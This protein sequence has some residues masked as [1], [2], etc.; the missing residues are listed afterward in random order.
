MMQHVWCCMTMWMVVLVLLVL[1]VVLVWKCAGFWLLLASLPSCGRSRHAGR[2]RGRQL[3]RWMK[4]L[5][6]IE[7]RPSQGMTIRNQRSYAHINAMSFLTPAL[8]ADL[9]NVGTT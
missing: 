3:G 5:V 2:Y 8:A 9:R 4:M 6:S 7:Q 1:R